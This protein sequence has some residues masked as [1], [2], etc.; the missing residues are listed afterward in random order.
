MGS[1][2]GILVSDA[3]IP[4]IEDNQIIEKD[5]VI[6]KIEKKIT[7]DDP[8]FWDAYKDQ[9]KLNVWRKYYEENY[10]KNMNAYEEALKYIKKY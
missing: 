8:E 4:L 9:N 1:S 10:L 6:E 2:Q 7:S 3:F 5:K